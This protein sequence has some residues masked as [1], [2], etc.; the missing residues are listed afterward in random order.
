MARHEV[1]SIQTDLNGAKFPLFTRG[2]GFW[3]P[4]KN[5]GSVARDCMANER[6]FLAWMRT[7]LNCVTL[8]IAIVKLL[9]KTILVKFTG[10]FFIVLGL[11]SVLYGMVRYRAITFHVEHGQ[12]PV[13]ATGPMIFMGAAV[14]GGVLALAIAVSVIVGST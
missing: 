14:A 2:K 12:Y 4:L 13:D 6:T 8:G 5:T 7:S 10:I 11:A 3:T 9:D 1:R